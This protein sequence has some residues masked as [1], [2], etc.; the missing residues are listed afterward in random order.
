MGDQETSSSSV[1]LNSTSSASPERPPILVEGNSIPTATA[2][3]D[4]ENKDDEDEEKVQGP[5]LIEESVEEEKTPNQLEHQEKKPDAVFLRGEQIPYLVEK[6]RGK[7]ADPP[8]V[9]VILCSDPICDEYMEFV[10]RTGR[11]IFDWSVLKSLIISRLESVLWEVSQTGPYDHLPGVPNTDRSSSRQ[12]IERIISSTRSL[13]G[14]PF[15]IQRICEL[16]NQPKK[17]Y[18][19]ADKFY[20]ALEKNI[21]V[22]TT[23]D[24]EGRRETERQ[25]EPDEDELMGENST[26]RLTHTPDTATATYNHTQQ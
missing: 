4:E 2:P 18:K 26:E 10:A 6:M 16:L 21:S 20:R 9:D 25:P 12:Y 5:L 14:V 1:I 3:V 8:L 11:P 23:V 13:A 19:R 17:H 22:V 24:G 7:D 15:T